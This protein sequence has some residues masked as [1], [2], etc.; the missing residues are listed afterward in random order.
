MVIAY[1]ENGILLLLLL[2]TA[3]VVYWSGF[4]ATDPEAPG[5]ITGATRFSET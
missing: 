2:L 1:D 3:S 5:L 4:L